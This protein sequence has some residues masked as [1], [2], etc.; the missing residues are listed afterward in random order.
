MAKRP[1]PSS[2]V[3]RSAS[4]S[5][6]VA[7]RGPT[8]WIETSSR[9]GSGDIDRPLPE[10]CIAREQVGEMGV[11]RAGGAGRGSSAG[12]VR[13]G[14]VRDEAGDRRRQRTA[15]GG[16]IADTLARDQLVGGA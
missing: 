14:V 16:P 10:R 8:S 4:A 2:A 13:G 12:A 9:R 5:I 3:R 1:A 7:K 15:V 6:S 11:H